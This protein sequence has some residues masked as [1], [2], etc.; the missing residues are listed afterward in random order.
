MRL[1]RERHKLRHRMSE[2]VA[3]PRGDL[4]ILAQCRQLCLG[5]A[6]GRKG[7]LAGA[8]VDRAVAVEQSAVAARVQHAATVMLAVYL[9]QSGAALAQQ[10]GRCGDRRRDGWVKSGSV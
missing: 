3:V 4:D 6:P 9:D 7:G 5:L 2:K 8:R 10:G 1:G